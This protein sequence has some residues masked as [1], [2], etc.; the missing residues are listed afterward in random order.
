MR[1]T[2]RL[3]WFLLVSV[4]VIAFLILT[5]GTILSTVTPATQ[6]VRAAGLL[7]TTNG[8]YSGACTETTRS[9]SFGG[10]V[11]VATHDVLCSD[12][13]V[14]GGTVMIHGQ[15]QGNLL[16]FGG[17]INIDGGVSGDITLFGGSVNLLTGARVHGSIHL[18]GG[19]E[20]RQPGA[21]LDGTVDDHSQHSLYLGFQGPGFSV[22]YLLFM[23][24]LSL[25]WM[26]FLPIHTA[27]VRAT[28]EQHT[29]RSFLVGLLTCLLAPIIV[30]LLLA[31]IIAIPVALIILIGLFAAWLSGIIAVSWAIGEQV[32]RALT[33]RPVNRKSRYL[34][35][36][37]GQIALALFAS[38]PVIGWFVGLGA[39]IIGLGAVLLSRFGT[40]MYGRPRQLLQV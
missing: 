34:A 31:L 35:V 38:L 15:L 16:A 6:V 17:T 20:I 26:R 9:P 23:I 19:Q 40:R 1:H 11:V 21:F 7:D 3:L 14:F 24:P 28:I 8:A 12:L 27:F 2:E 36:V 25:L 39:G 30:F 5:T 32:L 4:G 18:Y 37:L 33:S 10:T 22:W 13:T 29:R